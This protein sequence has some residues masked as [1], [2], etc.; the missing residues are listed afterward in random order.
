M[1]GG[2]AGIAAYQPLTT[3]MLDTSGISPLSQAAYPQVYE[4]EKEKKEVGSVLPIKSY[5]QK[6]GEML[7]TVALIIV[8]DYFVFNGA[9]RT[10]L[11]AIIASF[12]EGKHGTES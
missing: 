2:I 9:F 10:K 11:E 12:L 4:Q 8:L 1:G 7:I 5:F 6:H 3:A